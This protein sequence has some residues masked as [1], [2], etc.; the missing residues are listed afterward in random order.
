MAP[1]RVGKHASMRASRRPHELFIR[2]AHR[3]SRLDKVDARGPLLRCCR[4]RPS[5]TQRSPTTWGRLA[6]A[7]YPDRAHVRRGSALVSDRRSCPSRKPW[8]RTLATPICPV[9]PPCVVDAPALVPKPQE[10]LCSLNASVKLNQGA[11]RAAVAREIVF[12]LAS[13]KKLA[14]SW[15][16]L[17]H[18]IRKMAAR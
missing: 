10:A 9:P 14:K 5:L 17:G 13:I 8:I 7:V 12:H 1:Q 18:R 16:K 3:M 2:A 6:Q 15:R 4:P 11:I